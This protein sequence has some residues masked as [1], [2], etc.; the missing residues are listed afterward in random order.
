[1]L[2]LINIKKDYGRGERI[3]HALKGVSAEFGGNEFVAVLGA[4]GCG[5]TT[6]MN[7]V[8]GLD[9]Y[10][11]GDLIISGKSTKEY[12]DSDWNTYR[13]HSIGFVFQSYNLIPHMTVLSNVELALT[14][15]GV[16]VKERKRRAK[17]ALIKVGLADQTHKKPNQL[18][19]G[20]MQ[21]VA[22][23]RAIVNSPK[24]LLADEPTGAVD[25]DTGVH[26]M[27]TL[28]EIS[29]DCLVIMVTHNQ[30]LALE[31][32]DRVIRMKDGLIVTDEPNLKQAEVKTVSTEEPALALSEISEEN[33]GDSVLAEEPPK[34]KRAKMRMV[35]AI[36][37]SGAN[38]FNKKG[39]SLITVISGSISIICIALILAMNSG[40]AYYIN[41]FEKE[42]LGKYPIKV[43]SQSSSIMDLFNSALQGDRFDPSS[44]SLNSMIDLFKSDSDTREKYSD[45]QI[46]YLA[47][48]ML[49]VFDTMRDIIFGG[50]SHDL[51]DILDI[52]GFKFESDIS[53][54]MNELG[55][56]FK[57]EW[58]SLRVDYDMFLNIY[59]NVNNFSAT[60]INPVI[61]RILNDPLF[62]NFAGG[63]SENMINQMRSTFNEVDPW[64][65]MIDDKEVLNSQYELLAGHWPD[66]T[67][68]EGMKELVL[69]VDEYNQVED[70]VLLLLGKINTG[71]LLNKFLFNTGIKENYAFREFLGQEFVIMAPSDYYVLT[72]SGRYVRVNTARHINE[73]GTKI[74]IA[75]IVRLREG[76]SGG[77]IS[78]T[79]GYTEALAKHIIN[80][81]NESGVAK[82]QVAEYEKYLKEQQRFFEL[83]QAITSLD[84]VISINNIGEMAEL[85]EKFNEIEFDFEAIT[86]LLN[87]DL[88][89]IDMLKLLPQLPISQE[90][91]ELVLELAEML[92]F[93]SKDNIK[94]FKDILEIYPVLN[95][96]PE[97]LESL[98]EIIELV[99]E[100]N[101]AP[102]NYELLLTALELYESIDMPPERAEA[103][104]EAVQ[105]LAS[106]SLSESELETFMQIAIIASGLDL[107][108]ED[109]E[110]FLEIALTL[111]ELELSAE[112]IPIL[113]EIAR[114]T[115]L[116]AQNPLDLTL[117]GALSA[118]YDL[119]S[120]SPSNL[121]AVQSAVALI[122]A[123]ELNQENAELLGEM[124]ALMATVDLSEENLNLLR[125]L[126]TLMPVLALD[127]EELETMVEVARILA[128]LELTSENEETLREILEL[129]QA[130][131]ITREQIE[132]VREIYNL[133]LGLSFEDED[134][135]VF[136]EIFALIEG[137]NITGDDFAIIN[138]NIQ[139]THGIKSVTE[140]NRILTVQQYENFIFGTLDSKNLDKPSAV[141]F[142]PNSI[143]G[144]N[145]FIKLV[146]NFNKKIST[147]ETL[148]KSTT[149]YTVTYTDELSEITKSMSGMINTITY[150]LIG[151]AAMALIV[152]ML[153]VAIILYISVQDRIKE[154]GLLRSLGA[155]KANVSG[156]FIAETFI[157]GVISGIIGVGLS[158]I[159]ALPANAIIKSV[160]GIEGLLK[161][162]WWHQLALVGLALSITIISGLI[163]AMLAA[164]K[165][166][167]LALRAE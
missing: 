90:N 137:L 25:S 99:L 162:I 112:N 127:Q 33:A 73:Y 97:R 26:I 41:A 11:S 24:I 91:L 161:P 145:N 134:T 29:K 76:V 156:V 87:S 7:I 5:K 131:D 152:A 136:N 72:P 148:S 93:T 88:E 138:Q 104:M 140:L 67:T 83:L 58:G 144:R 51:D 102:E 109:L 32:S 36:K 164:K 92:E 52:F 17:E 75:G 82:A 116:L 113:L 4:S 149:D 142:Y 18:S 122:G 12:K 23:A 70:Y 71:H 10:T 1:M 86:E 66:Y 147:D 19:G 123:L 157:I 143:E 146:N 106:I 46:V 8:G 119:L 121:S 115:V 160:L 31:Y 47:K 118:Q 28:K 38:L 27:E 150:I 34:K 61:D 139:G 37:L 77:V 63:I 167:V 6:L 64:A 84:S 81:T 95:I 53:L 165:D 130:L 45:E 94:I 103:L 39:R 43:S 55:D 57:S 21:R 9:R 74:K 120:V 62:G 78:G 13:N 163:P 155:S 69:V 126:A 129:V 153:L 56:S 30:E 133:A 42:S 124:V 20:Q 79:I 100:L 22:I 16:S 80:K 54:F 65:M 107:S 60:R 15:S 110:A 159:L 2:K 48:I 135:S 166:P 14:L 132:A 108:G 141:Y 151:V 50:G 59:A 117:L 114:L 105:I 49:S 35:T 40:F 44:V 101:I 3:V 158:L 98:V 128:Q 68:E 111:A 154:I 89:P 96:T 85:F 125:E